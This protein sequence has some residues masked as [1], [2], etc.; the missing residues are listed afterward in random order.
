MLPVLSTF[1]VPDYL[2]PVQQR[3]ADLRD[4][5]LDRVQELRV[6]VGVLEKRGLPGARDARHHPAREG[7]P[8]QHCT[9]AHLVLEHEV[10]AFEEISADQDVA[11]GLGDGLHYRP[12]DGRRVELARE[13]GADLV[14]QGELARL[15]TVPPLA[16][17][18]RLLD[19]P[20]FGDVAQGGDADCLVLTQGGLTTDFQVEGRPVLAQPDRL[21]GPFG[22]GFD[23]PPRG[24]AHYR[25]VKLQDVHA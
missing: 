10:L 22:P 20:A 9:V 1:S 23:P 3:D 5:A 6:G 14:Q 8:L 13:L 25:N 16:L 2:A 11:V 12:E 17:L 18:E 21:P 7:Y 24:L 15:T 4:D 19:P